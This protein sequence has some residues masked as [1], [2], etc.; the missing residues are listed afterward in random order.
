MG[1]ELTYGDRQR[2]RFRTR[3]VTI[4][5]RV[6]DARHP[7]RRAAWRLN[8]GAPVPF[9]VEAISDEGVDWVQGY[10]ASPAELRCKE[11]GDFTI[12]VPA[13]ASPLNP[14][15]NALDI[16]VEDAGGQGVR[17]TLR[18]TWEPAPVPLP[19]DLSDLSRIAGIQDVGQVVAGAFDLDRA[20]NLIRSRA[21][22]VPD[23]LL[24]LGGP[25]S[26]QEATYR[27]RFTSF[28]GVKWLGPSDFFVGFEDRKPP[29]AIKTGW[30]S[31]G[32]MALNPKGEAR[33]FIA[34]GDHSNSAREWVVVTRPPAAVALAPKVAYRVRHQVLFTDGVDRCRFRIWAEGAPEP[35]AWLCAESDAGVEPGRTRHRA[36]SFGLFQH[37][38]AAI[39]WSDIRVRAL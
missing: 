30:S 22:V 8:G 17:R 12:E 28:E 39:E 34:W 18:F 1:I 15:D 27:V 11:Q 20:A 37:S 23:S 3:D 14:G 7:V 33:C 32:M 9:Y 5:G 4:P 2:F 16:E 31:A 26:S 21:P 29:I 10:K 36:A 35:D 38:G 25:H 19:L 6:I 13:A 24:V